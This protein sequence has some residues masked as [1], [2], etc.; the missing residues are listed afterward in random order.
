LQETFSLFETIR[1]T[2]VIALV[3]VRVYPDTKLHERAV[4]EQVLGEDTSL[5]EPAF[6]LTPQMD[7]SSLFRQVSAYARQRPNW[8]VP[9]LG[10]RCEDDM[11]SLLRK[12]GRKGPLWDMLPAEL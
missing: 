8:I 5:L 6:Y 11:L 10:I 4:K 9:G 3:G 12:M 2:A 7:A 1:P